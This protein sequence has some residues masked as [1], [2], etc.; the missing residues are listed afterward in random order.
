MRRKP[1]AEDEKAWVRL[2][3]FVFWSCFVIRKLAEAMKLS[4]EFEAERFQILRFPRIDPEQPQDFMNAHRLERFYAFDRPEKRTV[5][6]LWICSQLIHSFVYMPEAEDG[7]PL[8]FYFNSD[9]SRRD[10]L[11][12]IEWEEFERLVRAV[13]DDGVVSMGFNRLTG[14]V[15]KSREIPES[16]DLPQLDSGGAS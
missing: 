13:V 10:S 5:A 11:F 4:D 6:P 14:E 1:I 16:L 15:W 2:E 3:R 7:P 9:N 8:G 12:H